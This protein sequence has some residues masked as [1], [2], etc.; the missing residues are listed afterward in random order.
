MRFYYLPSFIAVG[1]LFAT[2]LFS[3]DGFAARNASKKTFGEEQ[4]AVSTV[5]AANFDESPGAFRRV[6]PTASIIVSDFVGGEAHKYEHDPKVGVGLGATLEI[7]R[8]NLVFETGLLYRQ[9]GISQKIS[10]VEV[11]V[12]ADYMS[13]PL[14][15]KYYFNGQDVSSFYLKG[16]LL[17][18]LLVS[19]K[20]V[21]KTL[22]FRMERSDYFMTNFELGAIAGLGGKINLSSNAALILEANYSRGITK[23]EIGETQQAAAAQDFYNSAFAFTGGVSIEI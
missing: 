18:A 11:V 13:L 20:V 1:V 4:E 7:G 19:K 5:E 17:P 9:Q 12:H 21:G 23:S 6:V 16:G 2:G 10:D 8:E 15:A 3:P 22:N 14:A